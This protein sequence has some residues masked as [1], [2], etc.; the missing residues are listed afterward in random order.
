MVYEEVGDPKCPYRHA[1]DMV[2]ACGDDSI[3]AELN[4]RRRKMVIIPRKS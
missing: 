2:S 1:K 4:R 3:A